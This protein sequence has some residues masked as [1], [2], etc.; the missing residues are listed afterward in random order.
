MQAA[1]E[2]KSRGVDVYTVNEE[3]EL[4]KFLDACASG[5]FTDFPQRLN[6]IIDHRTEQSGT[7]SSG[8]TFEGR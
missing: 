6:Q 4:V 7:V 2:M 1:A 5:V 3:G 8:S